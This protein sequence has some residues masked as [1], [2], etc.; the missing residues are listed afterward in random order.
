MRKG[1]KVLAVMILI[2][3]CFSACM[4]SSYGTQFGTL[5]ELRLAMEKEDLTMRYPIGFTADERAEYHF[6]SQIDS[7]SKTVEGYKL[8]RFGSPFYVSVCAYS[9]TS[10][11]VQSDSPDKLEK[12][13]TIES[14]SGSITIYA[15]KGY[16]D[17]LFLIGLLNID[18]N[19]YECRVT[20]DKERKDNAY[21]NSIYRDNDAYRQ[22]IKEIQTVFESLEA[23]A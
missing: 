12:L 1:I 6:V 20:A 22:A 14:T 18:G 10:A 11:I 19:H 4:G 13:E 17:A 7:G 21:V 3:F 2:V 9:G 5:E 16:E 8:Y 15:G 23:A